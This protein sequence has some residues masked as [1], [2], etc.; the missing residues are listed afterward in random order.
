[1]SKARED[2]LGGGG[3]E[4]EEVGGGGLEEQQLR[5]GGAVAG[6]GDLEEEE[7]LGGSRRLQGWQTALDLSPWLRER[8]EKACV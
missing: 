5:G 7:Q 2:A 8:K 4:E 3:L 1:L 6:R